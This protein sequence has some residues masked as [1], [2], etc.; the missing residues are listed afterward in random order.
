[1]C[2]IAGIISPYEALAQP[3]KVRSMIH[4]LAHRGPDGEGVWSNDAHTVCLGHKRLA[5]VDLNSS[6]NQ[7]MHYLH[8]VIVYNGEI[9]NYIELKNELHG[10]G[11]QFTT[12]SDT[13][14]V[15]AAFDC[16][17]SACL[18]KFDGMFAMVIYDQKS[19]QIFAARDRFGEKP[20]YYHAQYQERGK[21]KQLLF[22]SEM[23]ALW[24]AQVPKWLNGTMVL[25][26]L[27][28]GYTQ[29]P[30]KKTQTF[31]ND[32]LSLPPGHCLFIQPAA[33]KIQL[34]KWYTLATASSALTIDDIDNEQS[35]IAQFKN[36]LAQ[37]V[38]KRLRSHVSVGASLSGGLDSSAIVAFMAKCAPPRSQSAFT[39]SFPGFEKDETAFATTVAE[40]FHLKHHIVPISVNDWIQH[41]QKISYHQEEPVQSSSV[42]TQYLV[43]QC[44]RQQGVKVLLDG[45]GADEILGGYKKYTH[46]HLQYLLKH[47]FTAF[48]KALPLFQKNEFVET[49][50]IKNYL[51]AWYRP[52]KLAQKL[53]LHAA[54]QQQKQGFIHPDFFLQ[55]VN[56][57]TLMKPVVYKASDLLYYNTVH[58]G[59]TELLRYAD[60]NSMAHG[61]EVRLPFLNHT[62]VE[63]VFALPDTYKFN[64]G[65][66][67]W[68]LRKASNDLLPPSIVWRPNKIGFEPPQQVW[69][70]HKAMIELIQSSKE[71]LVQKGVLHKKVLAQKIVPQAAHAGNSFNWRYLSAATLFQ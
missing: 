54:A 21:F 24:A 64:N 68:L 63:F 38:E 25:N 51:A 61:C 32:I 12:Q 56:I 53:Q 33:G 6:A 47:N 30:L 1:M 43:Y 35:V 26:Y 9:Y 16:W 14:V 31:F 34:K 55:H 52:D 4:A 15:L 58:F 45:Q 23:K 41:W 29:N 10:L 2:G 11:Y 69:M 5:I 44:A 46:W 57:D 70:Q 59:L 17:G 20:F 62:L 13:E 65:F 19:N 8:Y 27:T 67:K 22:A 71:L 18:H 48:K 66:T 42:V 60:R 7:P 28:L 3:A 36:L 40:Q 37:S 50:G 39:A 49:W